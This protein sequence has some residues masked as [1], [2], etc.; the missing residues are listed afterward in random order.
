MSDI[1]NKENEIKD[2]MDD[3]FNSKP[4]PVKGFKNAYQ[5]PK[6]TIKDKKKES[7]SII[8]NTVQSGGT[9]VHGSSTIINNAAAHNYKF[10]DSALKAGRKITNHRVI[11]EK[12]AP[13]NMTPK[14][15]K[16][17]LCAKF[18][19]NL[20]KG[21]DGIERYPFM[22]NYEP[23]YS[24]K[25]I[26]DKEEFLK[27]FNIKENKKAPDGIEKRQKSRRQNKKD[28]RKVKT[29]RRQISL[30]SRRKEDRLNHLIYYFIIALLF[31]ICI[32][33]IS[34][35]ILFLLEEINV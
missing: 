29:N 31:A 12:V 11:G 26:E 34:F 18:K 2:I 5:V 22:P 27:K 19:I 10:D 30:S 20:V 14:E 28:Y 35:D 33:W 24:Q 16:H 6:P 23:D 21:W 17:Y 13:E 3:L 7:E 25:D 9:V 8:N 15:Y 1:K 32:L 4:K